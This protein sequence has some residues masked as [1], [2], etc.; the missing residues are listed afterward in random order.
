MSKDIDDKIRKKK[1]AYDACWNNNS[2]GNQEKQLKFRR[3]AKAGIRK[4]K[5]KHEERMAGCTKTNCK[6]FFKYIHGKRLMKDKVELIR[7][8]QGKLIIEGEGM[9][10]MG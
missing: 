5:R 4:A 7:D 8:K 6:M 9:A 1:E 10:E 2:N 3:D